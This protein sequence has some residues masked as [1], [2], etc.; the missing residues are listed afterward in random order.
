MITAKVKEKDIKGF[1]ALSKMYGKIVSEKVD[2]LVQD[3]ALRVESE[4]KLNAPRGVNSALRASIKTQKN[5]ELKRIVVADTHYA[6]YVEFGTKSKVDIPSGL[7]EYAKQ[8]QGGESKGGVKEAEESIKNWGRFKKI[9][10]ENL[11]YLVLHI[12]TEGIKA[13]PFLFPAFNKLYPQLIKN[14][15]KELGAKNG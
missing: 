13:Q 15:K 6:P 4:A 14:I 8:F 10:E 7:E 2:R 3:N 9:P 11:D 12:L 5:E 1:I